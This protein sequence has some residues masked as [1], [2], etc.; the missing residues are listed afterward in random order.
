MNSPLLLF[1]PHLQPGPYLGTLPLDSDDCCVP[2]A[3]A[4]FHTHWVSI[5]QNLRD[6]FYRIGQVYKIRFI[7]E[8]LRIYYYSLDGFS[9]SPANIKTSNPRAT[10]LYYSG[11]MCLHIRL[12]DRIKAVSSFWRFYLPSKKHSEMHIENHGYLMLIVGLLPALG[13]ILLDRFVR[14]AKN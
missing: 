4:R 8:S 2:N 5:P 11:A 6:N 9:A 12:R 14:G 1:L 3:S 7:N 13:L 10:C